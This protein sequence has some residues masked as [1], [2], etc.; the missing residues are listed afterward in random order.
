ML[1]CD[2]V[3]NIVK[4]RFPT[5]KEWT[6]ELLEKRNNMEIKEGDYGYGRVQERIEK[7]PAQNIT[8]KFRK[9]IKDSI[10]IGNVEEIFGDKTDKAHNVVA[11]KLFRGAVALNRAAHA[12]MELMRS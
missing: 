11:E 7:P 4:R 12:L 8:N 10:E 3:L 1:Y 6:Q 2:R 9:T 5:I